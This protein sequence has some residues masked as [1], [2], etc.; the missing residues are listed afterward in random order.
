MKQMTSVIFSKNI[1]VMHVS[2]IKCILECFRYRDIH[3]HRGYNH[4]FGIVGAIYGSEATMIKKK[5]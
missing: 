5:L 1:C 3:Y 2:K 4:R